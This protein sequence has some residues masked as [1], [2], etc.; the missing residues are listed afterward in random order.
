MYLPPSVAHHTHRLSRS[1]T[2]APRIGLLHALCQHYGYILVAL[3][4][5]GCRAAIPFADAVSPTVM[6]LRWIIVTVYSSALLNTPRSH[7]SMV[8]FAVSFLRLEH[9]WT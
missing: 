1:Q 2:L 4:D 9:Y 5:A 8:A 6:P 3:G 7:Q